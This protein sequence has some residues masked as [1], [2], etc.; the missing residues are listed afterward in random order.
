MANRMGKEALLEDFLTESLALLSEVESKLMELEGTPQ[1]SNLL[2]AIFRNFHTIKGGA[3]F[4]NGPELV[5]LCDVTESLLDK[6]RNSELTLSAELMKT[7]I[8]VTAEVREMVRALA[9]S[10]PV[11][12]ASPHLLANLRALLEN[13]SVAPVA[14]ASTDNPDWGQLYQVLLGDKALPAPPPAL[15]S[16]AQPAVA[17]Q[18]GRPLSSD[19]PFVVQRRH[20]FTGR[21]MADTE[22]GK[23]LRVNSNR[24]GQALSL[25]GQIELAKNRLAHLSSEILQGHIDAATLRA[26]N[27]SVGQLD[28]LVVNLQAAV[29]GTVHK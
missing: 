19:R 23:A 27:E 5:T 29:I 25:S 7:I 26:L 15:V 13:E 14:P 16:A 24:L 22:S 28:M 9:Q 2:N 21:R 4:L 10:K 17:T 6:L 8:A 20:S 12:A 3:G 11:H 1:D 18:R